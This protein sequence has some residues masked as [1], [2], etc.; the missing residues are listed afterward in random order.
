ME[1]SS[2]FDMSKISTASKIVMISGILLLVDTFLLW[3]KLCVDSGV[4]GSGICGKANA[5]CGKRKLGRPR[6]GR[7][8]LIA[9]HLGGHPAGGCR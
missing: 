2:G 1:K 3:Q 7:S 4:I 6:H 8:L 5:W 9:A